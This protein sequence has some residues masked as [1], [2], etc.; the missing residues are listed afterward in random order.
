M[1]A[2]ALRRIFG[3][4]PVLMLMPIII[5]G[6]PFSPARQA[7]LAAVFA[8][9]PG[10]EPEEAAL[11]AVVTPCVVG[12]VPEETRLVDDLAAAG[13]ETYPV[14]DSEHDGV[15][16]QDLLAPPVAAPGQ[17]GG[18]VA[19]AAVLTLAVIGAGLVGVGIGS[20]EKVPPTPVVVD[21][22]PGASAAWAEKT[23]EPQTNLP[24]Q[25]SGSVAEDSTWTTRPTTRSAETDRTVTLV[26]VRTGRH[27]GYDRVVFEFDGTALPR[28]VVDPARASVAACGSGEVV[29]VEGAAVIGVMFSPAFAGGVAPRQTPRLPAI[30]EVASACSG[31]EADVTWAVGIAAARPYRTRVLRG[32]LRLVLDV[33]SGP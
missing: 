11:L 24:D 28:V 29:P 33:Q 32:P 6:G 9:T 2:D 23:D 14:A 13:F 3:V 17:A 22:P 18:M 21:R 5:A 15:V 30:R 31:F 12:P 19:G 25:S 16:A 27:D 4:D 1:H 8:R 20:R 26:A 7:A 10:I